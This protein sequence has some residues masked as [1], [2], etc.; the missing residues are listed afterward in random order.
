MCLNLH[1]VLGLVVGFKF[2]LSLRYD[3]GYCAYTEFEFGF[4]NW[5]GMDCL[6]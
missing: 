6:S 3:V 5:F 2:S 4:G 1:L